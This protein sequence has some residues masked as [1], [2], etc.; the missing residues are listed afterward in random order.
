MK[1][2]QNPKR[3]YWKRET[4]YDIKSWTRPNLTANGTIGGSSF[5][6]TAINAQ[7]KYDAYYAFNN[8]NAVWQPINKT[9][10]PQWIE[11]YNPNALKITQIVIEHGDYY[12]TGGINSSTI[13][14]CY[15][16]D[17]K[18]QASEDGNTWVDITSGTVSVSDI[19]LHRNLTITISNSNFYK[20]WRF[21]TLSIYGSG[22]TTTYA[23]V[24][25]DD[26]AITA[27]QKA[28]RT[29]IVP[30]TESDY[31]YYTDSFEY[32]AIK[33]GNTYKGVNQ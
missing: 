11:W 9:A 32:K 24:K 19:H 5:A 22:S 26:I 2:V 23:Y 4:V 33:E 28:P 18:L 15:I 21:D 17:W 6:C 14:Q 29:I 31:D 8:S 27:T 12:H 25:I 30:G 7:T 13:Y 16:Q 3:Y 1:L 10:F 20:Y